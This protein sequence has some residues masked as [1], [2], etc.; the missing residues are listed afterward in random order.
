MT[1]E[2]YTTKQAALYLG[3]TEA[4]VR[5]A[6]RENKLRAWNLPAQ[7]GLLVR[8]T[9]LMRYRD[10]SVRKALTRQLPLFAADTYAEEQS[11]TGE[12]NVA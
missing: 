6:I 8:K 12:S 7:R 11:A 4:D 1:D 2:M 10:P 9:D 3:I 5:L